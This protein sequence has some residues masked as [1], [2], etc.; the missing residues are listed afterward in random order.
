MRLFLAIDL[1]VNIKK[2]L[3]NQLTEIKR[4][5][6]YFNW[7][8]QENFHITLLF[9]GETDQVEQ[10][11]KKIEEAI[12]DANSFNLYPLKASLFLKQK[13]V[14]Y[15][16]F[17]RQKTLEELVFK[18]KKAFQIKDMKKFIPHLTIAR[19]KIPGKQQYFTL[20]KKLNQ[21]P[22]EIDFPVKNIYLFQS[23]LAGR[24]PVYK[25]IT[26]FP[27]IKRHQS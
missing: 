12:F 4:E 17:R 21:L 7:V 6:A 16:S 1:P 5:Y 25:K 11:K 14:L 9:F 19:A 23:I 3:D 27:L 8:T 22:L 18:V 13:I 15:L 2:Q 20:K 26:T 10:I 24:K